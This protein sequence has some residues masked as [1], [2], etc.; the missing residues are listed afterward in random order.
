MKT[1]IILL[2]VYILFI[3]GCHAPSKSKDAH[4]HNT[5]EHDH[6]HPHE[7]EEH[8]HDDDHGHEGHDHE[9]E[10]KHEHDD[11]DHP[12]PHEGE[13]HDH[14][15]HGHEG[16]D[17]EGEHEHEHD[18]HD[19][20]HPHEGEGHDHDD[21]GHEGH[22][23]PH[24]EDAH[25]HGTDAHDHAAEAAKINF[26]TGLI[27]MK[28]VDFANIIKTSGEILPAQGDERI[29]TAVHSG[30]IKFQ[31]K[32]LFEGKEVLSGQSLFAI[33]GD[34]IKDNSLVVKYTTAKVSFDNATKNLDRA[35]EL[36]K[37][38]IIS[39]KEYQQAVLEYETSK[40]EFDVMAKNF[41]NGK[42]II[43]SPLQGFIKQ[44]NITD[45]Q[46]VQAGQPLLILAK[47]KK[48]ILK[49]EV[50]QQYVASIPAIK[51]AN[52]VTPYNKQHY[53]TD[54]LNG[55]IIS[56]GKTTAENS[57][58]TPVFFEIDNANGLVPGT[59][60]EIYLKL[61]SEKSSLVLPK[62]ALMEEQGLLYVFTKDQH[63]YEKQYITVGHSDGKVVQVLSG[64]KPGMKVATKNVYRIKLSQTT[65][66]IPHGH[67]H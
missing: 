56:Y 64:L 46:F 26:P 13:G 12:H 25:Q 22:D 4:N 42:Q 34:E 49:A 63:G 54:N 40:S 23:H 30:V 3:A 8:D 44:I 38:T 20:P 45:G 59:F 16:H 33:S 57:Y 43:K 50:D 37:D 66:A 1:R 60:V 27:T 58:Y 67:S 14:D 32:Q 39:E 53:R 21:H 2:F 29:I 6:P 48:L 5:E 31:G 35:K 65:N 52:F 61:H 10:H 36:R 9:G 11:H 28:K 41:N 24:T 17:H 51:N 19:H 15:D 7:G 47:N 62:S 18:D 55:K